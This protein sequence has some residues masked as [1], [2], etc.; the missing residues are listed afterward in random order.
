MKKMG[1][2]SALQ[3]VVILFLSSTS[4][5]CYAFEKSGTMLRIGKENVQLNIHSGKAGVYYLI[6]DSQGRRAG[7]DTATKQY[8]HEFPAS[9][10]F[11]LDT[12]GRDENEDFNG[13]AMFNLTTGVYTIDI[14]GVGLTDF[15]IAIGISR[16]TQDEDTKNF[17]FKSLK[18]TP[19]QIANINRRHTDFD[20]SGLTD[21]GLISRF[22]FTYTSDPSKPAATATRIATSESLK[23]DI[24]L[25]RKI[26]WIDNDG[27]VNSLLAKANAIEASIVKG[28]KETAGNQL[29]AFVNEVN[30]QKGKQIADQAV[31]IFLEDVQYM[32]GNL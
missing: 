29:N 4:F 17:D 10:G 7:Y 16:G 24:T 30:A 5:I 25:S 12:E 9:I 1:I 18:L 15:N 26:G 2:M 8:I 22:Q 13:E 28:D 20:F 23:Q 11:D 6:T 3:M 21:K 14:I 31:K 27:I 32:L 19:E